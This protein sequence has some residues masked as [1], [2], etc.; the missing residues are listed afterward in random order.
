MRFVDEPTAVEARF[1]DDGDVHPRRFT[2]DQSWL[3]V[4]DEGRQ[5]TEEEGCLVLVMVAGR[6]NYDLVLRR[7]SL[8]WWVVRAPENVAAA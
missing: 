8:T 5:W 4:S 3:D 1:D 6:Q 2:W 7:Q